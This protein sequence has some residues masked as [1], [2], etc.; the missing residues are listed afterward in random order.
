MSSLQI[1]DKRIMRNDIAHLQEKF[2]DADGKRILWR[3]TRTL[4]DTYNNASPGIRNSNAAGS[5]F[6]IL[7]KKSVA[8]ALEKEYPRQKE[9]GKSAVALDAQPVKKAKFKESVKAFFSK[10][11]QFPKKYDSQDFVERAQDL[12][13][14]ME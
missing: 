2:P 7:S 8:D 3:Y 12:L 6:Y 1:F 13:A 9:P 14:R 5:F 11:L 4:L 10:H